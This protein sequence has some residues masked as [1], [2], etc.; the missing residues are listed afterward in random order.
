[1]GRGVDLSSTFYVLPIVSTVIFIFYT[2]NPCPCHRPIFHWKLRLRWLPNTNEIDTNMKSTSPMQCQREIAQREVYSTGLRWVDWRVMLGRLGF[3]LGRHGV[4]LGRLGFA[5]GP[6]GFLY[7]NMLVSVTQN[8]RVWVLD[9]RKT[10]T[11]VVLR[12][13]GI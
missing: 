3:R 12:C 4:A 6:K 7:T 5:L 1:M 10:P 9:Q 11:R 2:A 13:S 8:S